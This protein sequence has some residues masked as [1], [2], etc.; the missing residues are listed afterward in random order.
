MEI[1]S[2]DISVSIPGDSEDRYML[3]IA[4]TAYNFDRISVKNGVS[5][6]Y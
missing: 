3:R 1:S 5:V 6:Y 2:N 4:R